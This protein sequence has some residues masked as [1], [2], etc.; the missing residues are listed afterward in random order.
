MNTKNMVKFKCGARVRL[1][2]E[3]VFGTVMYCSET[4]DVARIIK[5][6]GSCLYVLYS[7]LELI[8]WQ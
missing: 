2:G 3:K 8:G 1:Y 7:D 4:E 5:D 6:S